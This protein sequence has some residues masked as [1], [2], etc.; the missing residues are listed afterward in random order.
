MMTAENDNSE[1]QANKA[2]A[3]IK[4]G[5]HEART[6]KVYE[7]M[8][9]ARSL[10]KKHADLRPFLVLND[11]L[12]LCL[13]YDL[14]I[15]LLTLQMLFAETAWRRKLNARLLAMTLWECID[16]LPAISGKEF[17]TA[18]TELTIGDQLRARL[19][20]TLNKMHRFKH[21]HEKILLEIRKVAAAH[22]EHDLDLKE[23]HVVCDRGPQ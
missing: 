23:A 4:A 13:V 21:E 12:L 16:D 18:I 8:V 10:F 3:W 2:L 14:D 1:L 22:R 20:Y 9:K 19:D 11:S 6:R 7:L 17:R 15:S 5:K